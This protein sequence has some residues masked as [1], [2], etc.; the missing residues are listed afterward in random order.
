MMQQGKR[1]SSDTDSTIEP[2]R[3]KREMEEKDAKK[4]ESWKESIWQRV[5]EEK[6]DGGDTDDNYLVEFQY[7][8]NFLCKATI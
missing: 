4:F 3:K 5:L 7:K 6:R 2:K 1:K 8:R